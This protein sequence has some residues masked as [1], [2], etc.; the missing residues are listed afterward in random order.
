M[1][2]EI[3]VMILLCMRIAD[4]TLSISKSHTQECELKLHVLILRIIK[5][6]NVFRQENAHRS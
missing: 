2:Y 5:W 4:V 1:S 6:K 3:A